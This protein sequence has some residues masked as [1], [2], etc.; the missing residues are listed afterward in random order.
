MAASLSRLTAVE[1]LPQSCALCEHY[2]GEGYCALPRKDRLL[3]GFI[4]IPAAVVCAKFEKGD[5]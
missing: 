4:I 3:A 1:P 5:A 2:D